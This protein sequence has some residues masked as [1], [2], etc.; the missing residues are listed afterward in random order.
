MF[1]DLKFFAVLSLYGMR[2]IQKG[3]SAHR[4]MIN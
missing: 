2:K 4:T 1:F 3:A